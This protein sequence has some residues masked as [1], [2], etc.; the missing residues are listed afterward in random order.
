MDEKLY[1]LT[2]T[3]ILILNNL[4]NNSAN[5][6]I[7]FDK[8]V[9][10]P[11]CFSLRKSLSVATEEEFAI[12][13]TEGTVHL[14]SS[15]GTLLFSLNTNLPYVISAIEFSPN[16]QILACG[17]SMKHI[18]LFDLVGSKQSLTESFV[19]HGGMVNSLRF[20]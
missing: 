1:V 19:Y 13:T 14:L 9:K 11:S 20:S 17:N 12:A 7:P 18:K 3:G 16:G 8:A 15:S 6:E 5:K 10:N 4:E 2:E